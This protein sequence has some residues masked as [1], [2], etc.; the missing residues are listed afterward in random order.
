MLNKQQKITAYLIRHDI[1]LQTWR[2]GDVY[3]W[4]MLVFAETALIV[5]SNVCGP[6]YVCRQLSLRWLNKWNGYFLFVLVLL[7]LFCQRRQWLK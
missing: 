5:S 2:N 7:M 3:D 4:A 1:H 6:W